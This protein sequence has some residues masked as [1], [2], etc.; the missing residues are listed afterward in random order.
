[1]DEGTPLTT[2]QREKE[3]E[4][5]A[6]KDYFPYLRIMSSKWG[7]IV[8]IIIVNIV[9]LTNIALLFSFLTVNIDLKPN[10]ASNQGF[11][12]DPNT[13]Q[14]FNL[15][16]LFM[17]LGLCILPPNAML[18]YRYKIIKL[19]RII[20]KISHAVILLAS[21]L[22]A[23]AGFGIVLKIKIDSKAVNFTSIHSWFGITTIVML[24]IQWL[25]GI[26]VFLIPTGMA[27][28]YKETIMVFHRFIGLMLIILPALTALMGISEVDGFGLEG[29]SLLAKF[30]TLGLFI[31]AAMVI[32]LLHGPG[33]LILKSVQ[34]HRVER[35]YN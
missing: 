3:E 23:I 21:L 24:A 26:V 15:H 11:S 22:F 8:V 7:R 19:D 31:Q 28:R 1:M 32:F 17:I 16:K 10:T 30:L 20:L 5:I 4:I 9:V 14:F 12:F 33:N 6:L 25:V 27:L 2:I 18:I 34:E 13:P 29:L 35:N